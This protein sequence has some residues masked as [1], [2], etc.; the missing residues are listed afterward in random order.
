MRI[1]PFPLFNICAMKTEL[2]YF[3]FIVDEFFKK[4]DEAML[5]F[6]FIQA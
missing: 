3:K 4:K 1:I 5:L 2:F 6:A